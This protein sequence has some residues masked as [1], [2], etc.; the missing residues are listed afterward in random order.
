[1]NFTPELIAPC[2]MNRGICVAFFEYTLNGQ[3]RKH[4]CKSCRSRESPCAFIKKHCS[5]LT[6]RKVEYCFECSLFPCKRLRKLDDR[7]ED[8][9][10]MSMIDSLRHNQTS[11]I[12]K[13]LENEQEKWKC[14]TCGGIICVHDRTCYSCGRSSAR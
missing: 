2:G 14:P 5:M 12:G 1:M 13:F 6:T 3:K 9:Y 8:N 10:G 11:G 7:Y 4:R